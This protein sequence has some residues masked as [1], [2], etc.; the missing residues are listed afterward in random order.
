MKWVF[1]TPTLVD[2]MHW[3]FWHPFQLHSSLSSQN[4]EAGKLKAPFLNFLAAR[5]T[6]MIY[7]L[8]TWCSLIFGVTW[9]ERHEA[10]I[11]PL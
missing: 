2:S 3:L 8:P 4:R 7:V 11:L 1:Y 9:E 6:Y 10:F 5:V